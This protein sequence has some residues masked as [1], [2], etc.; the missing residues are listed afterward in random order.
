MSLNENIAAVDG[1]GVV[2]GKK[3]G[4]TEILAIVKIDGKVYETNSV[5]IKVEELKMQKGLA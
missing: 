1:N 2:T 4:S 3:V 5:K